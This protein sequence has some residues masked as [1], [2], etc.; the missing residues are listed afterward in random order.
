MLCHRVYNGRWH[1]IRLCFL[2]VHEL[3]HVLDESADDPEGLSCGSPNLVLREAIKPLQGRF[4][5]LVPDKVLYK[6]DCDALS[7][8]TRQRERTHLVDAA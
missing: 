3:P 4:D 7:K 2:T 6:I 1:A 8:V 5:V